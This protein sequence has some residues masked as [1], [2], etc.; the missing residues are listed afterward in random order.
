MISAEQLFQTKQ[1]LQQEVEQYEQQLEALVHQQNATQKIEE[2]CQYLLQYNE[3]IR[4]IEDRQH[5]LS[6]LSNPLTSLRSPYVKAQ[7]FSYIVA[8]ET[9]NIDIVNLLVDEYVQQFRLDVQSG[10]SLKEQ[11]EQEEQT[12]ESIQ[13]E[14]KEYIIPGKI[15]AER[16]AE[17]D[18]LLDE[19]NRYCRGVDATYT[20]DR[21]HAVLVYAFRVA[22][23]ADTAMP[24][25][26]EALRTHEFRYLKPEDRATL[27]DEAE[28]H[29]AV[30]RFEAV[31]KQNV[32][33]DQAVQIV[34]KREEKE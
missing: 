33:M 12:V 4:Q 30:L 1:Q 11:K 17:I 8:A 29:I 6:L 7:F 3:V 27:L 20:D 18:D 15:T 23:V 2:L 24:P 9:V 10:L 31:K 21:A 28:E 25:I 19:M 26:V 16:F 13:S 32:A 22:I 14:F 34:A 5:V